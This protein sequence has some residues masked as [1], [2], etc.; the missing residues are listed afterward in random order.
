MYKMEVENE[1]YFNGIDACLEEKKLAVPEYK[2]LK[3]M[4]AS[5]I[6]RMGLKEVLKYI[7]PAAY[8]MVDT[9]LLTEQFV[10][11]C[12][13]ES[14]IFEEYFDSDSYDPLPTMP[15]VLKNCLQTHGFLDTRV[16]ASVRLMVRFRYVKMLSVIRQGRMRLIEFRIL[17]QKELPSYKYIEAACEAGRLDVLRYLIDW[18][19]KN[20]NYEDPL[21]YEYTIGLEPCMYTASYE[22]YVDIL[23][24]LLSLS[25]KRFAFDLPKITDDVATLAIVKLLV[26]AKCPISDK[27]VTG[28]A[29]TGKLQTLKYLIEH[30][31][32]TSAM[33]VKETLNAG[34][35]DCFLYLRDLPSVTVVTEDVCKHCVEG[36]QL[37]ALKRA[38]ADGYPADATMLN[39]LN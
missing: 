7:P 14:E 16:D 29:I 26:E 38:I 18:Y 39:L 33:I 31:G 5:D 35:Y 15:R 3:S 2:E 8:C 19:D 20:D 32:E 10:W 12:G 17:M 34:H 24:Y 36:N 4:T 6:R 30:G 25:E 11:I 22:G 13:G 9:E 37:T 27:N 21:D 1:Q 23:K 28:A